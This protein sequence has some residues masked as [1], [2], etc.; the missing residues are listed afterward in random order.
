LVLQSYRDELA[1]VL[2][3]RRGR[4]RFRVRG[5]T[6]AIR[7]QL[8]KIIIVKVSPWRTI[9]DV[10]LDDYYGTLFVDKGHLICVRMRDM[11]LSEHNALTLGGPFCC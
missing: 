10:G 9:L 2:E 6:N 5:S 11:R 4:K 1:A 7:F 3:E 8:S